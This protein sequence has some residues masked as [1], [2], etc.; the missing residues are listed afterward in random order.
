MLPV[1]GPNI[2]RIAH[3]IR[4]WIV[5]LYPLPELAILVPAI[6]PINP[7]N[8]A[9]CPSLQGWSASC[10]HYLRH[11][12]K[13]RVIYVGAPARGC[14]YSA[15]S[16]RCSLIRQQ[17]TLCPASWLSYSVLSFC[18][19][20]SPL[21]ASPPILERNRCSTVSTLAASRRTAFEAQAWSI[22]HCGSYEVLATLRR[23][24]PSFRLP[25][26]IPYPSF[27][28]AFCRQS[29]NA[30]RLTLSLT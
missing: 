7:N 2:S 6:R 30:C 12:S 16:V 11:P 17:K 21:F 15:S 18:P 27:S 25:R 13:R 29:L 4:H 23:W 24:P 19:F 20:H 9:S 1:P 26:R 22:P 5:G 28:I 3:L 8:P 14:L 10:Q